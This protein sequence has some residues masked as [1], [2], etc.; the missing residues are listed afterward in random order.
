MLRALRNPVAKS[1]LLIVIAHKKS[2]AYNKL[3]GGLSGL[4]RKVAAGILG[5]YVV[6]F[7]NGSDTTTARWGDF[8]TVRRAGRN[9]SLFAGFAYYTKKDTSRTS[10]YY[11]DPYYV[12]FGRQSAGP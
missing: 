3:K 8:T 5:D 11:F 10:G 12:V 9:R 6:W 7:Q 4:V 1:V 2:S